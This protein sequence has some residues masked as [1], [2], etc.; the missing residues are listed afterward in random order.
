M[1]KILAIAW[2]DTLMRFTGWAEWIF[3]I[4][5]PIVFTLVLAG[6]TGGNADS[7]VRLVV[8]DEANSPLSADLVTALKNSQAVRPDLL[9]LSQAETQFS[10]R[11]VSAILIIP[12]EFDLAHLEQGSIPLELRQQ[13]NNMDAMVAQRA[14]LSVISRVSSAADI[15]NASV[16]KAEQMK[17]FASAADRQAYFD[18]SLKQAQTLI[19]AAPA[20]VTETSGNTKDPVPYNPRTNSSAGQLITWV[21]VPLI[22][23]SGMFAYERQK[24][25]L[26]RL[27]TTPTRKSTYLLGTIFGQVVTAL[28]QMSLL[29]AFGI[30]VMKLNWDSQPLALGLMMVTSALAAAALGTT[31]GTLVKTEGQASGLSIMTGMVMALLGG[32]WYPLEMFPQFVQN[33]VKV[34]PTTWAMRGLLDIV[35]RGQGL[36]AVLPEAGILLGFAALFFGIGIWRF[37]YE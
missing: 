12:A 21:F 7:R 5:L 24:G 27:L 22:G 23:I 2:K 17:P 8:V 1:K 13:P 11:T 34:L 4:V 29:I 25:T 30:F 28:V 9:T 31:L 35:L 37:R 18:A 36:T 14:V 32:C 10:Q 15:A 26:R 19:S 33:V 6:G 3:F 20:R 16:A